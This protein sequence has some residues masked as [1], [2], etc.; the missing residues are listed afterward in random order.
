MVSKTDLL[1][2]IL[3]VITGIVMHEFAPTSFGGGGFLLARFGMQAGHYIGAALGVLFGI[4][5]LALY[6]KVNK[7]TLGV[8]ALSILLGGLFLALMGMGMG[9]MQ[10]GM[11]SVAGV[12]LLV[13]II[14]IIG[15]IALKTKKP[16]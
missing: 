3:I 15:S 16:T 7:V 9:I 5:G 8:S 1:I 13:G 10:P 14:G 12:T 6:K 4:V 2:G 11:V